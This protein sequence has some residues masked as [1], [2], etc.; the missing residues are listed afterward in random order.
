M[1]RLVENMFTWVFCLPAAP[2]FEGSLPDGA[3]NIRRALSQA[4]FKVL[5]TGPLSHRFLFL[6]VQALQQV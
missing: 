4:N 6:A 1:K 5:H 3:L 2:F